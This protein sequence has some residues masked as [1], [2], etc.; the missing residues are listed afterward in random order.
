MTDAVTGKG[1]GDAVTLAV[2][3]GVAWVT[4]NRPDKRNAI[5]PAIVHEM[6]A[7]MDALEGMDEAEVIVITG[8]GNAFS[9]GQDLKEYFRETEAWPEMCRKSPA[10]IPGLNGRLDFAPLLTSFSMIFHFRS[11]VGVRVRVRGGG[12]L[13][14]SP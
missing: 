3:D 13:R 7:V 1:W 10:M 11:S 2:E 6:T 4:L 8:A 9:A 5:N 12:D 14:S